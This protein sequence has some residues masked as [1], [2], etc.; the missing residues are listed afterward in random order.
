M[1]N[2]KDKNIVVMGVTNKWSIAWACAR[3]LHEAGANLIFTYYGDRS[4][5][6]LEKLAN[7]EN[8][9]GRMNVSCDVTVDEDIERTFKEIGKEV[10]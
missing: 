5:R 9:T 10:F 4:L 1:L 8:I 2:L 7:S 6:S 3:Q